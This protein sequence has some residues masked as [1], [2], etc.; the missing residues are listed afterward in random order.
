MP[1]SD[2]PG[3]L[4]GLFVGLPFRVSSARTNRPA[5]NG[6]FAHARSSSSVLWCLLEGLRFRPCFSRP[7]RNSGATFLPVSSKY[8][9][10]HVILMRAR[11][12]KSGRLTRSPMTCP[13]CWC[14]RGRAVWVGVLPTT[15]EGNGQRHA[16]PPKKK[17]SIQYPQSQIN[18]RALFRAPFQ[19]PQLPW[20][21]QSGSGADLSVLFPCTRLCCNPARMTSTQRTTFLAREYL[22]KKS[23]IA[24][25][26]MY[27]FKSAQYGEQ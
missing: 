26:I 4:T 11:V 6:N 12:G 10:A 27:H 13:L 25:C 9:R 17:R 18:K 21:S 19:L 5:L 7:A 1:L 2:G 8:R 24:C 22:K 20:S 15:R 3:S 16:C 23:W 14:P